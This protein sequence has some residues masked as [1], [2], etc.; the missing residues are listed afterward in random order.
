MIRIIGSLFL[1]GIFFGA[2]PCLASCGPLILSYIIGTKKN[3]KDS[4][5]I[6]LVFSFAR[7]CVYLVL[8][9]I[10]GL[11]GQFVL[12]RF[13][14]S[15]AVNFLYVFTG[16]FV[17]TIG[18]FMIFGK[19]FNFK[20]CKRLDSYLIG[21][22][23]KSIFLLGLLIGIMPCG[24]LLG[25]IGFIAAV[26]KNYSQGLL[27]GASFGIGTVISPMILLAFF[28]GAIPKLLSSKPKIY[29]IFERICG[30]I[31]CFLGLGLIISVF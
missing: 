3:F 5:K 8:G 22:N 31:I 18:I 9:L 4:L 6:W 1:S 27:Y 15:K 13:Y 10:A 11:I 30:L 7:V 23:T 26:S 20:I 14:Q 17:V 2:G 16:L 25:I 29:L 19:K 24:P 28:A 21:N 12:D